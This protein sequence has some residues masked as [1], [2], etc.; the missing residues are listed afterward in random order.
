MHLKELTEKTNK[1]NPQKAFQSL[2]SEN[3]SVFVEAIKKQMYSGKNQFNYGIP[4]RN[5]NYAKIKRQM[6][7]G[8]GGNVDL[9]VTGSFYRGIGLQQQNTSYYFD[10]SDE[11]NTRLKDKYPS[12]FVY[13]TQTISE[14][15]TFIINT[16]LKFLYV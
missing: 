7:S 10:S 6:N 15:N 3:N 4:Y 12:M 2:V 13:N 9:Y 14:V 11:K 1:L 8:A 5:E 16:F